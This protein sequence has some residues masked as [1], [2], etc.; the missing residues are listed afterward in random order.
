MADPSPKGFF[1]FSFLLPSHRSSFF[2]FAP[3]AGYGFLSQD[4]AAG[5]AFGIPGPLSEEPTIS[6]PPDLRRSDFVRQF[7]C[8]CPC[9][10]LDFF[11]LFRR[12]A[13]VRD[14]PSARLITILFPRLLPPFISPFYLYSS[15]KLD[16][17]SERLVYVS[18]CFP[19]PRTFSLPFL[20][21]EA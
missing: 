14:F 7:S 2:S 16:A 3:M 9:V 1:R 13:L 20:S 10:A 8:R 18:C 21:R 4:L 11:P 12:C 19:P 5:R 6:Q 17:V 15:L